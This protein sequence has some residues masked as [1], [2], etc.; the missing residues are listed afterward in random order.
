MN[1]TTTSTA[2]RTE[3]LTQRATALF[4]ALVMTTAMLGGIDRLSQVDAGQPQLA[5]S[6]TSDR[7]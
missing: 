3:H 4:F 1:A 2:T 6:A 7:A 5:Q